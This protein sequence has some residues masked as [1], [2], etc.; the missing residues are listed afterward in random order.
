M[1]AVI[2]LTG[3]ADKLAVLRPAWPLARSFPWSSSQRVAA[4]AL[5]LFLHA[6]LPVFL[7]ALRHPGAALCILGL[8]PFLALRAAGDIRR[9]PL[10]RTGVRP[11]L[12]ESVSLAALLGLLPGTALLGI[13]AAPAAFFAARTS[14]RALKVTRWSDLHHASFGDTLSWSGE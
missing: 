3:L 1:A 10:L 5:F 9:V 7:V 4:D 11:F 2:V 12:I 14:E 6:L 13:A 8:L